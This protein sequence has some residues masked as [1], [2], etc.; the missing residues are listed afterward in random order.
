MSSPRLGSR[1]LISSRSAQTALTRLMRSSSCGSR[2]SQV[3][4]GRVGCDEKAT[5][6]IVGSSD[7]LGWYQAHVS[8][9]FRFLRMP[10]RDGRATRRSADNRVSAMQQFT[11]S[12]GNG[13]GLRIHA[14]L[15]ATCGVLWR[16]WS[17]GVV[18]LRVELVAL[19][20]EARHLLVAN[21]DPFA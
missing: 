1:P 2:V 19:D 20:I 15:R 6:C 12:P 13:V 4:K 16:A 18:P 14:Q 5:V 21:P 8:P 7:R 11:T 9:V 17:D 10:R 3:E